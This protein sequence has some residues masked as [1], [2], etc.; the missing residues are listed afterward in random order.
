MGF[1]FAAFR[2]AAEECYNPSDLNS[3]NK[4]CRKLKIAS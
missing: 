4:T 1:D 3:E 2:S